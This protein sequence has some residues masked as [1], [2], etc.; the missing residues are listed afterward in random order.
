MTFPRALTS[1]T[2]LFSLLFITSVCPGLQFLALYFSNWKTIL[3]YLFPCIQFKLRLVRLP[4]YL[5]FSPHLLVFSFFRFCL[6]SAPSGW[7]PF[8]GP[9]ST[10]PASYSPNRAVVLIFCF[11][12]LRSLSPSP[13]LRNISCWSGTLQLRKDRFLAC[14]PPPSIRV[15]GLPFP[16]AYNICSLTRTRILLLHFFFEIC[17]KASGLVVICFPLLFFLDFPSKPSAASF[18]F[19]LSFPRS[20]TNRFPFYR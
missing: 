2:F 4:L 3:V 6:V 8:T 9:E 5:S 15:W 20:P 13:K 18:F 16:F 7:I 17:T 10:C 1:S 11:L 14:L 12:Q 19:S